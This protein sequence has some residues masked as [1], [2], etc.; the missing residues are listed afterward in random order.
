MP[1]T[2]TPVE[3]RNIAVIAHVDHGK[4]TLIDA[5]LNYS[6]LVNSD[7]GECIM[8]SNDQ[9]RERGITIYS[10]NT[11]LYYKNT[12]INII[13]TPGHADFGSEVERVLR[14]I[15]S[16]LLVV[17]A[18]EGPMPQTKFVLKK[19][20]ELGLKPLVVINKID[21]PMARCEWVLDEILELFMRLECNDEQLDFPVCYTIAREGVAKRK[22]E[23]ESKDMTALFDMILNHVLPAPCLRDAPLR[24]Q[25][26]NLGYDD[27][28]GRLAIGRVYDGVI[29]RGQPVYVIDNDGKRRHGKLTE[30]FTTNGLQKTKVEEASAGDVVT[31]AGIADIFVGETIAS[32]DKAEALPLIRVDEPLLKMEFAANSSPFSGKEGTF[33]TTREIRERLQRELE[34]NVGLRIEFTQQDTFVVA[35]RG[36]L[37]LAI[38]IETMRREGMELQIGAPEVIFMMKDGAKHEPFERV[39]LH[40][41]S[42][43]AGVIIEKMN[44]RKG[45]MLNLY[46]NNGITNMEFFV[47]TRG[48]IGFKSEFITS[49]KGEGLFSSV[50]EKYAP[51][52]GVIKH[53]QVGSMISGET[54]AAMAYSLWNLQD[55]GPLFIHPATSV[56]EGMIIGEHS[57]G[58]DL[59]V[60]PCK[61]KKL[62]NMRASGSDEAVRLTP[63]RQI[64]LEEAIAYIDSDEYIEVTPKS[65]RL[66][67]KYLTEVERRRHRGKDNS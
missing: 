34:T 42:E 63:P 14:M 8:D 10:K 33:V 28:L 56:Y 6:G 40:V 41:P 36:E 26:V 32:E 51:Y 11:A 4:T 31:V 66:R 46:E 37:H 48:L 35:G 59:T 60:N 2:V 38:L 45:E 43:F 50:F 67:K 52:K 13:D 62:T 19:S 44:L 29:K 22:L 1:A 27:F 57:K 23:E 3:F 16:V 53:R 21:K 18:Y 17:D 64:T 54:G 20:L 24:M 39:N 9:E 49:T 65:I 47:S 7:I 15:D 25:V 61:N 55:R 58:S 30:I 5:M 12:K